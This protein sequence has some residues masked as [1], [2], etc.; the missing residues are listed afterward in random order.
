MIVAI[1]VAAPDTKEVPDLLSAWARINIW[2][3]SEVVK[4]LRGAVGT[5]IES[6]ARPV[7]SCSRSRC[8]LS[9]KK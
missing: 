9:G 6:R 5:C 4:A 7:C 1:P 2:D 3:L 8:P